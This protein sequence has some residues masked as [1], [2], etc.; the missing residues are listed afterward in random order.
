MLLGC[1]GLRRLR[2][3][4]SD[5]KIDDSGYALLGGEANLIKR[6]EE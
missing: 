6:Q 3:D 2:M 1:N 4:L 5:Q